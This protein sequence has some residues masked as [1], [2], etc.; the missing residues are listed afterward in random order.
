ME[1]YRIT[2]HELKTLRKSVE[3]TIAY[4]NEQI[5]KYN[6]QWKS[7][8]PAFKIVLDYSYNKVPPI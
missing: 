8:M 1:D 2:E 3:W 7:N 6:N 5:R 4:Y